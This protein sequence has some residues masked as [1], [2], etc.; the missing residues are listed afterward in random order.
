MSGHSK[1][2]SIKHKKGALD[3][4]RGKI[5]TKHAKLVAIAARHGADPA[6]N[7]S[8][9]AAID[10]ARADNVPNSNIERAIKKG[11]GQDKDAV[12]YEEIYYEG[13][14]PAGT[15]V[16]VHVITD[17][18]N[19]AL[20][21]VKAILSRKGGGMGTTGS[22]SWIFSRKGVLIIPIKPGANA[23]DI[24][25]AIIDAG[26]MDIKRDG[27]NFEVYTDAMQLTTVKKK[28]LESGFEISSA[29]ITFIPKQVVKIENL[30]DAQKVLNLIDSLEE[31][32][33]V[34][35]V[36]CNFDI[37]QELMEKLSC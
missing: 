32:D 22:A 28:L 2:H 26:A 33:D 29:E 11:S 14:G 13:F 17:N 20:A 36:Y 19:R 9:R 24:E 16:Y 5:F 8:L 6:I 21:D 34:S 10:S 1:W 37:S 25:L 12:N 3:A 15:A 7:P 18:K 23:D 31:N 35:D 27:D 30:E 4:K